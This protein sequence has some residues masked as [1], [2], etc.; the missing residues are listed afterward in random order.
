MCEGKLNV[1]DLFQYR[2][3]KGFEEDGHGY[4]VIAAKVNRSR[5]SFGLCPVRPGEEVPYL[6]I[7]QNQ[8]TEFDWQKTLV[9]DEVQDPLL[10]IRE[11][12]LIDFAFFARKI[13]DLCT[14]D[15]KGVEDLDRVNS[16]PSL[17]LRDVTPSREEGLCA[18]RSLRSALVDMSQKL[19]VGI[20]NCTPS[21]NPIGV[22]QV[23]LHLC[24]PSHHFPK[25]M[26]LLGT[27]YH[28][29]EGSITHYY[30]PPNLAY[31]REVIDFVVSLRSNK[32]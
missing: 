5:E 8:H 24:S 30:C 10:V 13:V 27:Q 32:V 23:T 25:G 17:V 2:E 16:L 19:A 28:E 21:P 29:C 11:G 31:E 18:I 15:V 22:Q 12:L 4:D 14:D 9:R 1:S 26:C 7:V 6:R 3:F 20:T